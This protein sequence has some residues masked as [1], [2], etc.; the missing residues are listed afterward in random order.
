MLRVSRTGG[1]TTTSTTCWRR[2]RRP[3]QPPEP[4]RFAVHNI[5]VTGGGAELIDRPLGDDARVRGLELAI[6]FVS[7]PPSEREI[8][9]EPHLAFALD[10]SRFDSSGAAT[11]FAERGNGE[12][13]VKLD[14]FAVAPTSAICR[15]ACRRSCARRR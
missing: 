13:R 10:G 7:S 11:P 12:L 14:G 2:P 8:K 4:T 5:V 3:H 15:A 1:A 6:P 9:V